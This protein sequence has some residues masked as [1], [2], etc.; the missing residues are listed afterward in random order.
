MHNFCNI[1]DSVE[2]FIQL[3]HRTVGRDARRA[4]EA[5]F[6][7][8]SSLKLLRL[9]QRLLL[10]S[11][12]LCEINAI[13]RSLSRKAYAFGY[14]CMTSMTN[15][16][17]PNNSAQLNN[18]LNQAGESR[19]ATGQFR[20]GSR[21]GQTAAGRGGRTIRAGRRSINSSIRFELW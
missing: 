4:R 9:P 17:R 19:K 13:M 11:P 15:C 8:H 5:N 2:Y 3:F 10:A 16:N 6:P 1:F 12:C 14:R 21:K 7:R 20:Q 18:Q